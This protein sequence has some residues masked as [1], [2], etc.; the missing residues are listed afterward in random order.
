MRNS[1]TNGKN[2]IECV[3][4]QDE[5]KDDISRISLSIAEKVVERELRPEDHQALMEEFVRELGDDHA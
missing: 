2:Q 1:I 3:E 5:I 4:I